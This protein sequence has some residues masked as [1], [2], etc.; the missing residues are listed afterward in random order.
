M[1]G[2]RDDGARQAPQL[3][4]LQ[5]D[6]AEASERLNEDH[7]QLAD[8]EARLAALKGD[9]SP[10][11][12]PPAQPSS[13][14]RPRRVFIVGGWLA[15]ALVI[16]LILRRTSE[17]FPPVSPVADIP[18]APHAIDPVALLPAAQKLAI[19]GAELTEIELHYVRPDGTL[20]LK[21]RMD[22]R[23]GS[24]QFTFVVM[25]PPPAVDSSL[26]LGAAKPAGEYRGSRVRLDEGGLRAEHSVGGAGTFTVFGRP[27]NTVPAPRCTTR[28]VWEAALAAGA[29]SHAVA[30]LTYHRGSR[31]TRPVWDFKINGSFDEF[32][33]GDP[34]CRVLT[35]SEAL[36]P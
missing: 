17:R 1:S 11:P 15:A 12:P 31:T 27:M 26:P 6:V 18:G 24:A 30:L 5:R 33:I 7:E 3:E 13:T 4:Q 10:A 25:P 23:M 34:E 21:P 20:D 14:Q 2:Y 32:T 8:L 22:D 28:Q 29:P 19:P 36:R 9:V 16:G 35:P